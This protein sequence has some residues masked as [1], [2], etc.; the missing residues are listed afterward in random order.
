MTLPVFH[1]FTGCDTVSEFAGRGKKTA[2]ETWK[3][4][5]SVT[6]ALQELLA[7]PSEVSEESRLLLERFVVLM[8]R[9]TSDSLGV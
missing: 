8:Y 6:D 4:F 1:V 3:S 2:W 9:R 5:P 7:L